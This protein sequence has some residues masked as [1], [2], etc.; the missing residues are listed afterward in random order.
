SNLEGISQG[1]YR[2]TNPDELLQTVAARLKAV[3]GNFLNKPPTSIGF[4][5]TLTS[6]VE[7]PTPTARMKVADI[8]VNDDEFGINFLVLTGNDAGLFEID[9]KGLYLKAGLTL[10][11]ESKASYLVTVQAIDTAAPALKPVSADFR[12]AIVNV[13]EAPTITLPNDGFIAQS[14]RRSPLLFSTLP[15]GITD[16]RANKRVSVLLAVSQGRIGAISGPG[17]TIR[18]TPGAVVF[19]GTLANLNRFFTRPGGSIFY[20]STSK[21]PGSVRLTIKVLERTR[22][23]LLRRAASSN[24]VFN[25][26][27]HQ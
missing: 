20:R 14:N 27:N 12:L 18:S 10:D 15:L 1:L 23:G 19:S 24:I 2:I 25:P 8:L 16:A 7:N 17:V 26:D 11:Y 21:E 3:H 9:G 4:I 13:K 6:L 5:N 22:S